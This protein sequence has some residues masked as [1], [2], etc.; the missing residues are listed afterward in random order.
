MSMVVISCKN[1]EAFRILTVNPA[2]Y[3]AQPVD[4]PH[5]EVVLRFL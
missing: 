3:V 2:G 5:F 4:P 1:Q